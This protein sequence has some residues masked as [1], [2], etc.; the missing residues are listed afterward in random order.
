MR[1]LESFVLLLSL[2]ARFGLSDSPSP[3]LRSHA[4]EKDLDR[5]NALHGADVDQVRNK[6]KIVTTQT[7]QLLMEDFVPLSCN[8]NLNLTPCVSWTSVF[9]NEVLFENRVIVDCGVCIKIDMTELVLPQG[10]DIRGKIVVPENHT[11]ALQTSSITVQGELEIHSTS[12]VKGTPWIRIVMIGD[13]EQTFEPVGENA[14]KCD[15]DCNVDRNAI[16]VAGG[17]VNRTF[18][19]FCILF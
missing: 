7:R 19:R 10:L 15:A 13:Q 17:K 9:G 5:V 3:L 11:L 2:S 1:P 4:K 16:T 14:G 6:K 18:D 8:S 12:P